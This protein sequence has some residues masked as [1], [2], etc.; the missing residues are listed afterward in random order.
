MKK[1]SIGNRSVGKDEPCFIIAEAG[2]NHNGDIKLARNL[3]DAAREAGADAVK[4]QT[5]KTE[6]LIGADA[7]KV[8]YQKETTGADESLFKMIQKLEFSE[9]EFESLFSYANEKGITFLS[10]P[11]DQSSVD[12]LSRLGVT[13]FKIASGEINNFP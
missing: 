9:S 1:I 5:F 10:S 12:L 4:F 11:F 7:W 13:A 8:Q 3:I 6:E 2:V